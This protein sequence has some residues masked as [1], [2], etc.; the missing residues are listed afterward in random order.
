MIYEYLEYSIFKLYW[1]SDMDSYINRRETMSL[2][3]EICK[4][5]SLNDLSSIWSCL[6]SFGVL[7]VVGELHPPFAKTLNQ[8]RDFSCIC[9]TPTGFCHIEFTTLSFSVVNRK[10]ISMGMM[11]SPSEESNGIFIDPQCTSKFPV[12]TLF[13]HTKDVV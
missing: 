1:T 8:V 10:D 7:L 9:T 13:Y 11:V 3:H 5:H 2:S 12:N 4:S 6:G